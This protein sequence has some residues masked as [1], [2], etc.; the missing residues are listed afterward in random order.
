MVVTKSKKDIL[1]MVRQRI[2]ALEEQIRVARRMRTC[3][4]S[5]E[6]PNTLQGNRSEQFQDVGFWA[7]SSC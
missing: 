5:A 3:S 1:T 4:F 7:G 2:L 6:F